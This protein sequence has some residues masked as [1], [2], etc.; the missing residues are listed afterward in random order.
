VVQAKALI[1]QHVTV[2]GAGSNT[3]KPNLIYYF[4]FLSTDV[5]FAISKQV[6][7][8]ATPLLHPTLPLHDPRL[9]CCHWASRD[10]MAPIS[11]AWHSGTCDLLANK[12][13]AAEDQRTCPL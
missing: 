2:V 6:S 10:Q 1:Q 5:H 7:P 9:E 11:S 13:S 3:P 8:I 4:I 12:V